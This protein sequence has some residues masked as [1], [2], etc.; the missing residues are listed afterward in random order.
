MRV[1]VCVDGLPSTGKYYFPRMLFIFIILY[2]RYSHNFLIFCS[3]FFIKRKAGKERGRA[4]DMSAAHVHGEL[5]GRRSERWQRALCLQG[6][7][8]LH[9]LHTTHHT[10]HTTHYTLHTTPY[11]LPTTHYPLQAGQFGRPAQTFCSYGAAR[12]HSDT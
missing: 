1:C 7:F 8:K 4:L 11:T 2:S 6:M 5:G 9:T 12:E 3:I 10:P